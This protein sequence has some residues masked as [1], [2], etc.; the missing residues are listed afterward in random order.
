M[1]ADIKPLNVVRTRNGDFRLIDLDAMVDEGMPA[2]VKTSTAYC[3]P[4]MAFVDEN[5]NVQF[6]HENQVLPRGESRCLAT[7]AFDFWS[8]GCVLF[9]ALV[10]KP[11]FE[12][13]DADNIYSQRE[14][15]R[16]CK[17]AASDLD[18]C[19]G[20][21]RIALQERTVFAG[22]G[23]QEKLAA[24]DLL[25]WTLHPDPKRRPQSGYE[26]LRHAFFSS[27]GAGSDGILHMSHLHRAAAHGDLDF[28]KEW[29]GSA[30][31]DSSCME[32]Q[33]LSRESLL[34]KTPLHVAALALQERTVF[35][36]L[37]IA[38][39][40]KIDESAS[41]F[42]EFNGG[43]EK[44][45]SHQFM[46]TTKAKETLLHK[47][48]NTKDSQNESPLRS[49]LKLTE[50]LEL[51]D[52]DIAMRIIK[53]LAKLT[54]LTDEGSE[55]PTTFDVGKASPVKLV[56]DYFMQLWNRQ[57]SEKRRTLF[58]EYMDS[59]REKFGEG[60]A[61][62]PVRFAPAAAREV[63]APVA[64]TGQWLDVG[65]VCTQQFWL[66][67]GTRSP[68]VFNRSAGRVA[69]ESTAGV[70]VREKMPS[71]PHPTPA[72][73]PGRSIHADAMEPRSPTCSKVGAREPSKE[74]EAKP[75]RNC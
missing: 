19:L 36:L 53:I 22:V 44:V 71:H 27:H 62:L 3:P 52:L 8:F 58:L 72:P 60:R 28:V 20:K 16:L 43:S 29:V 68:V 38:E 11:L 32:A 40:G 74:C 24:T 47:C 54:D 67:V 33:L 6:K 50:D 61:D 9:R 56:R 18:A 7:P 39:S 10:R 66:D 13:D 34:Q 45:R 31:G 46:S 35:A 5:S 64:P 1:H 23:P 14:K 42:A 30:G 57:N 12:S 4:E 2:G 65:I 17:W 15:L 26:L 55:G 69:G 75:H 59:V 51:G 21:V 49:L 37:C 41:E 25:L 73:R 63:L 48:L 70:G